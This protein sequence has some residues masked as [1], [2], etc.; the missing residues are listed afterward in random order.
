[1]S[2]VA[3]HH[4]GGHSELAEPVACRRRQY[5]VP[6]FVGLAP[7]RRHG[8]ADPPVG[9]LGG[10]RWSHTAPD[11]AFLVV[12]GGECG[13]LLLELGIVGPVLAVDS[14]AAQREPEHAVGVKRCAVHRRVAAHAAIDGVGAAD[15]RG[16]R[17]RRGRRRPSCSPR[18]RRGS[19]RRHAGRTGSCGTTPRATD[20][21]GPAS[22]CRR[23][24]VEEEHGCAV[25]S[26]SSAH[27]WSRP[28]SM[29][30][31]LSATLATAPVGGEGVAPPAER[32]PDRADES[33]GRPRR[34]P[35]GVTAEESPDSRGQGGG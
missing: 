15:N 32:Y 20:T 9:R 27:T 3:D 24:R 25:C 14:G 35:L 17:G 11:Q 8:S 4:H 33:V 5:L 18:S 26:E 21:P 1:M 12:V 34:D 2:D 13:E 16:G 30:C 7:L 22:G 31:C 23:S 6:A 10:G 28:T 19:A 29:S